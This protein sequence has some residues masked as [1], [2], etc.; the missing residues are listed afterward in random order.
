MT[1]LG[2][3]LAVVLALSMGAGLSVDAS[4][5]KRKAPVKRSKKT[6]KP[7]V[8]KLPPKVIDPLNAPLVGTW[9]LLDSEDKFVKS[10]KIVLSKYG[11]F[12]FIGSAWRSAGTFK[13]RDGSLTLTWTTVDKKPVAPGTMRKVLPVTDLNKRFQIDRF[14]YGKS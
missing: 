2:P 7:V 13:F 8:K 3:F 6:K 14:R 1:R 9:F 12:D 5:Q 4:A 11:E 10:T